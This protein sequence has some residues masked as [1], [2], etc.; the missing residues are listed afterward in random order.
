MPQQI[1]NDHVR[2]SISP[3]ETSKK[4][5]IIPEQDS[6]IIISENSVYLKA[7]K[8]VYLVFCFSSPYFYAWV[9][10]N[11]Q[12]NSMQLTISIILET[13]FALNICINFITDY[14]PDG[15]LIPE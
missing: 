4:E 10:L 15:E 3:G 9:A 2:D 14:V 13:V 1:V 5:E 6:T 7:F 11:G 8:I 12:E